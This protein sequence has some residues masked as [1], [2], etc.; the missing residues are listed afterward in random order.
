MS[1]RETERPEDGKVD[2]GECYM[3]EQEKNDADNKRLE[4]QIREKI[5]DEIRN[6]IPG[7]CRCPHCLMGYVDMK[8]IDEH[9]LVRGVGRNGTED[10]A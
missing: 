9:P 7:K 5:D 1:D 10:H 8:W 3:T 4:K 2:K 6:P